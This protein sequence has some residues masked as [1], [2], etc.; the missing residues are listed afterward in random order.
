[1]SRIQQTKM[2]FLRAAPLSFCA[3]A[4]L[5]S[6]ACSDTLPSGGG[7]AA[8]STA[9]TVVS[10]GSIYNFGNNNPAGPG[11]TNTTTAETSSI[12]Q[13]YQAVLGRAPSAS[14]LSAN[15]ALVQAG[16]LTISQLMT[17]L[18]NS[19]ECY[20]DIRSIFIQYFNRVATDAEV[21]QWANGLASGS[22]AHSNLL[23]TIQETDNFDGVALQYADTIYETVVLRNPTQA[24]VVALQNNIAAGQSYASQLSALAAGAEAQAILANILAISDVA[25]SATYTANLQNGSWD[26]SSV[27][28]QVLQ[29]A[30]FATAYPGTYAYIAQSYVQVLGRPVDMPSLQYYASAINQGATTYQAMRQNL[31]T[32]QECINAINNIY[33]AMLGRP[34]LA[35]ELATQQSWLNSGG[36]LID[37]REQLAAS[38]TCHGTPACT[39]GIGNVE[40]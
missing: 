22:I 6:T 13:A 24:E 21:N 25:N 3:I 34:A 31:A 7:T 19:L 18:A 2:S 23:L 33:S 29:S 5:L 14:E 16:T 9:A 20:N 32:S 38:P 26:M 4:G 15:L 17:N 12:T 27:E 11:N 10:S 30:A 28:V 8:S 39:G 36:N 35:A 1:M 40:P 37:L